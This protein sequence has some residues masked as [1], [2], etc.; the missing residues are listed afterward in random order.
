MFSVFWSIYWGVELLGHLLTLHLTF[1]G[2]IKL[3]T[4]A[5]VP[6]LFYSYNNVWAFHFL[7]ILARVHN[8]LLIGFLVPTLQSVLC[9]AARVVFFLPFLSFFFSFLSCPVLAWPGLACPVL[10]SPVQ[11][12]P[13]LSFPVQDFRGGRER[14]F[15]QLP[16]TARV[17]ALNRNW[18][19][20]IL[21]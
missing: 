5:A 17:C 7:Y 12:C 19:R 4:T 9:M 14:N 6:F 8:R 1:W 10:S 16:P 13:I 20:H 18:T 11:P 2:T 15:H 21:V 3:F